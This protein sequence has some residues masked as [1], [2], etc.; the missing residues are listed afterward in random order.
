ML[1][2]QHPKFRKHYIRSYSNGLA[3]PKE[4]QD[5]LLAGTKGH[6]VQG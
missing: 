6:S 1:S 4:P 3:A 2:L 5:T